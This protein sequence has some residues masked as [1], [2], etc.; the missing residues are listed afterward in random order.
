MPNRL[1]ILAAGMSS[2]MKKNTNETIDNKLINE[3]NNLPK[4]MIGLGKG[5]RPFLDYLLYNAAKGG[6]K[7]VILLLNPADDFTQNYYEKL[8]TNQAIFGLKIGFARQEIPA[9]RIKPMGTADAILQALA[10]HS[11]WQK[12]RF[13]VCNSDNIYPV[14]VFEQLLATKNNAMIAFDAAAYSIERVRN[15]AIVETDEQGFLRDLIEKPTDEEWQ[16]IQATMLRI[17]ISWN[18]F[19]L[20][21]AFAIPFFE[22]TPLHPVRNEKEL[23]VSIRMMV[24]AFPKAVEVIRMP[25]LIPDLTAKGDI[26]EVQRF[27]EEHFDFL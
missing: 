14:A 18:I 15:C 9:D 6:I 26:K 22:Q 10:Q 1:L 7:E 12:G 2:R 27:I 5:G 20:N 21:A 13:I 25:D 17:G 4:C 11:D 24:K 16:L 3:A 8:I 19:A 23:P